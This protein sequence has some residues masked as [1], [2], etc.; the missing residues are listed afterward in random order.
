MP[1]AA[2]C[3][4]I[5]II[6]LSKSE[7]EKYHMISTWYPHITWNLKRTIYKT[8]IDSQIENKLMVTKEDEGTGKDK[9]GFGD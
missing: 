4:D 7:K 3:M 9:V 2:T 6:I 8:E 5:E 1:F